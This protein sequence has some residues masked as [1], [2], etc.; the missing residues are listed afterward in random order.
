MTDVLDPPSEALDAADR[1]AAEVPPAPRLA[2][3]LGA[4]GRTMIIA[5][6]V[7]LL[8]VVF[9]LW[10]TDI[11]EARAQNGLESELD[12]R[13]ETIATEFDPALFARPEIGRA[14]V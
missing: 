9:Q 4:A 5:G 10:G 11:Q 12:E 1:P 2:R 6:I 8:F 7:V 13:F 3:V 14:H